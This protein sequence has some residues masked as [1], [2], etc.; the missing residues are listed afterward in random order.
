MFTKTG[1]KKVFPK[2]GLP[3]KKRSLSLGILFLGKYFLPG[4][5]YHSFCIF[6]SYS[7]QFCTQ[8]VL[9]S[10][11]KCQKIQEKCKKN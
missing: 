8:K 6:Y 4:T 3:G 5:F 1:S 10:A 2:I 11:K 9:K 7:L